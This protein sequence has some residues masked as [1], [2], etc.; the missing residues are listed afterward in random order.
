M[1]PRAIEKMLSP[2]AKVE[3]ISG[4]FY[5]LYPTESFSLAPGDS[6][7][8][9]YQAA[10]WM[11]K[12]V[13]G[14]AGLYFV[15]ENDAG[16]ELRPMIVSDY[17]LE[18]FTT[19][20]QTTRFTY[21]QA[22][23]P[24]PEIIYEQNSKITPLERSGLL[25][26]IPTPHSYIVSEGKLILNP[27]FR[28]NYAAG[29]E[30]EAQYLSDQLKLVLKGEI[31][32][33]E[34]INYDANSISLE[35]SDVNVDGTREEAYQL[36]ITPQGIQIRGA[37]K[38]GVFYAIQ[39]LMALIQP[40]NY[41]EKTASLEIPVVSVE[42]AP[43]FSYRGL[44]LDVS[45]NFQSKEAVLRVLDI[46]ALYKLNKLHL[47]LT[48]DE[49]WRLE[50][51]AL[52]ELTEVGSKRG[53]T[54]TED[55]FLHPSYGSGPEVDK[56]PGSGYYSKAEFIEIIRYAYD[57]H[58][59]V[60]PE[61]NM[62]GH[63]RAAIKAMEARYRRFMEEGKKVEAEEY[64]LTD[65]EDQSE[66]SSAQVYDDNTVCV[67]KES[68]YRFYETAVDEVIKMYEE[69]GVPLNIIHT[70]GD[71]V[72]NGAWEKS[73][74]CA[75][76]I[77]QE[78]NLNSA[79][80]LQNYFLGRV[81]DILAER[82][83]V[84]GGWEEIVMRKLPEGGW[85][86][87][88]EYSDKQVLPYV[89][90][91]LWGNQDLGNKLANAGYPIVVCNVTNLYFDLAYNKDTKEPG[92]YWGGLVDTRKAYELIPEATLKSTR[93][94]AMEREFDQDKE[95]KD[96][97]KLKP[98][99]RK[100]IVG[101]QGE[102]WSETLRH[103]DMLEY[104]LLP[105]MYG[106]AERAWAKAD[107]ENDYNKERRLKSIDKDWNVFANT[108]GQK[109]LKRIDKVAGGYNYRIPMPG[110]IIEDGMLKANIAF[111]GFDIRYTIDGSEP[112]TESTLYAGPVEVTGTVQL[113]AFDTRG[114][115]SRTAVV[116]PE[117]YD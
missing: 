23:V 14:P 65:F 101:I 86:P 72:P 45:R 47:H 104:Y 21:D 115:S 67:C 80:D 34:G 39:S 70:G 55:E 84:A 58:I 73:P 18:P 1:S 9:T 87:N 82:N 61:L 11:I 44:H 71:E 56:S 110:A 24:T 81:V 19:E 109:E 13:D 22:P 2:E 83:L 7:T 92:L 89:W 106:L 33:Q 25:P 74:I 95:F 68:V 28:I 113:K 117:L 46:M 38:A 17:T 111:P 35:L 15:F 42:D 53:H 32:V 114:R 102:L 49:G 4:D 64:L 77:A 20:E 85:E 57:R 59:E 112:T 6:V 90:N 31:P 37:D 76:L 97:E 8:F 41:T 60:I 52:P 75:E 48:D 116:K 51:E 91:N 96:M 100:N 93:F 99:A 43:R 10:F 27:D 54:L 5:R 69:A 40:E 62:P 94:D 105:K 36:E 66:Y 26:V 12:E 107:W 103:P 29:L 98:E 30:K 3:W 79:L 88:P 50:I 63:A 78:E 108:L 16:D